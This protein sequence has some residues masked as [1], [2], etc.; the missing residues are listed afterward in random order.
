MVAGR[1]GRHATCRAGM[2]SALAVAVTPRP[3]TVAKTAVVT[4]QSPATLSV[5]QV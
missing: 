5:V 4:P 3:H 1:R 2:A